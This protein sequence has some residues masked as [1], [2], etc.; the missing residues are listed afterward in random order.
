MYVYIHV[1][2]YPSVYVYIYVCVSIHTIVINPTTIPNQIF[3]CLLTIPSAL[4]V[5]LDSS[6]SIFQNSSAFTKFICNA[7]VN[8]HRP[9][10]IIHKHTQIIAKFESLKEQLTAEVKQGDAL[11]SYFSSHYK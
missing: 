8:N 11:S 2:V 6:D 9:F 10:S 1:C 3:E 5:L 7:Q 4:C